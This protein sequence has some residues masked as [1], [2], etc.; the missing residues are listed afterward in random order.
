MEKKAT[1]K[2]R[3][4]TADVEV[5]VRIAIEMRQWRGLWKYLGK[6][7]NGF[8]IQEWDMLYNDLRTFL[9]VNEMLNAGIELKYLLSL[10]KSFE[11]LS[12]RFAVEMLESFGAI[13]GFVTDSGL[14]IHKLYED[15]SEQSDEDQ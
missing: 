15:L 3:L 9:N 8:D 14:A 6:L 13:Y 11:L 2:Y 1:T 12:E 5:L 7:F 4:T 10:S